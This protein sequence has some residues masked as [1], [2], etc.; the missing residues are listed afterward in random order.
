MSSKLQQY[1]FSTKALLQDLSTLYSEQYGV[2]IEIRTRKTNK[3]S[4]SNDP[5]AIVVICG[6]G[7]D[8]ANPQKEFEINNRKILDNLIKQC[9]DEWGNQ[10]KNKP[11]AEELS[12]MSDFKEMTSDWA[13]KMEI[14][15]PKLALEHNSNRWGAFVIKDDGK[16]NMYLNQDL[17]FFSK[18]LC[19][20]TIVHELCHAKEWFEYFTQYGNRQGSIL[21]SKKAHSPIFWMFMDQYLPDHNERKD[22]LEQAYLDL[23]GVSI[24]EENDN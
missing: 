11:Q 21:Y 14:P 8:W 16:G 20:E 19:E 23:Y 10:Y 17:K 9:V 3:I 5:D 15:M 24:N 18:E 6:D 1:L 13:S 7:T 2:P 4:A 22:K 12:S